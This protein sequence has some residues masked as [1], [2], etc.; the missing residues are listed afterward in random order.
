MAIGTGDLKFFGADYPLD[1]SYGGGRMNGTIVINGTDNNVFPNV[2]LADRSGGRVQMRKVYAAVITADTDVLL[3]AQV[4]IVVGTTDA[5]TDTAMFVFGDQATTRGAA[6]T[7]VAAFPYVVGEATTGF[8]PVPG[9]PTKGTAGVAPELGSLWAVFD[10]SGGAYANTNQIKLLAVVT[11]VSGSG[12]YTVTFDRDVFAGGVLAMAPV[13]PST[14][15]YC[16]GVAVTTGTS[17]ADS[18]DVDRVEARLVPNMPTY[19]TAVNLFDPSRLKIA[20]GKVPIFR[21]GDAVVLRDGATTEV[22]RVAFV[23]YRGALTFE[24]NLAHSYGSGS[25]VSSLLNLGD[26]GALV[27]GSF[28]QQTWTKVFS[29]ALIGN[30]ISANYDRTAGDISTTNLG[31]ATERWAIVFTSPTEFKLIGEVSGQIAAGDTATDF[32]P[33]NPLTSEPFL[34]ID[35][36]GWGSGWAL[37]NVLRINALGARLPFWMLRSVSPSVAGGDDFVSLELRGSI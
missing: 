25:T 21:P 36:A 30:P 2:A 34:T 9:Q 26:M 1:V 19:P 29:D 7:A 15:P 35:A 14:A 27:A 8:T 11:A 37:G 3:G 13:T 22:A 10:S 6:A 33:V 24:A 32:A 4:D 18:V 17:G 28:S 5:G 23:D 20:G 16:Y 31:G 12:P